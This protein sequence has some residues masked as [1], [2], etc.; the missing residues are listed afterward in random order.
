MKNV[1]FIILA[2][3]MLLAGCAAD[4]TAGAL[5]KTVYDDIQNQANIS[6]SKTADG[7]IRFF[8]AYD[9]EYKT[10]NNEM[11]DFWFDIPVEWKAVDQSGDGS[12]YSII[13]DDEKIDIK[14]YGVM[15][16]ESENEFY[17][18]LAGKNGVIS[19]FIYR[20]GWNGKQINISKTEIYY[21]RVDG[22]SYLVLHIDAGH[23]PGWMEENVDR[24]TY[25]AMSARTT[26][27]AYRKNNVDNTIKLSDLMIG[28]IKINMTYDEMLDAIHQKPEHEEISEYDGLKTKTLFFSDGTQIYVVNDTVYTVNVTSVDYATPRGL[29]PG[30]S[31]DR[32]L[33]LYG[34]PSCRED[35][36]W[37]YSYKGYELL[38]V[39]V[40]KGKVTEIQIDSEMWDTEI[41]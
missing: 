19:D 10:G 12:G 23:D 2:S 15:A 24:L 3:A 33:E 40:S 32:L 14:I 27:E 4:T 21:V 8:P 29:R 5:D 31:E 37:S 16:N 35:E 20:D 36:I 17:A 9:S 39:V 38:T 7:G 28:D 22:D 1:I 18:G 41:Y 13:A 6:P 25:I 26:R 11:F 34:E 30:D